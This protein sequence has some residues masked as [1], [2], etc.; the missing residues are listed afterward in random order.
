[1]HTSLLATNTRLGCCRSTI[2][3]TERPAAATPS[4]SNASLV[5][6]MLIA[7]TPPG[8]NARAASRLLSLTPEGS[9]PLEKC[10][11]AATT[12]KGSQPEFRVRDR[13]GKPTGLSSGRGP[14]CPAGRLA[15]DSP[16]ALHL[17]A[18]TPNTNTPEFEGIGFPPSIPAI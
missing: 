5:E 4:G 9:Q 10:P 11:L 15:A 3:R 18:G 14:A 7:A 13:S 17:S 6:Q 12:L 8:S 2:Y 16:T 1:M